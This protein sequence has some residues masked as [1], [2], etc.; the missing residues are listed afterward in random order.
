VFVNYGLLLS[1]RNE[2]ELAGVLAHEIAHVTQHHIARAIKAQSQQAITSAAA[3]LAAIVL[4]AIGGGGGGQA[5]EGGMAAAQGLAAQQQINFTRS[6]EEE[7]D[8]VRI[9]SLYAGGL[10]T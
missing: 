1:T 10:H 9:A 7:A 5:I 4:G 2:S 6:N 3:I 8:R